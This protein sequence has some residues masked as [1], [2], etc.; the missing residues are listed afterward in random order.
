LAYRKPRKIILIFFVILLLVGGGY[1][2][3]NRL[4]ASN[5]RVNDKFGPITVKKGVK[6]SD[7]DGLADWEEVL[8][9]TDKNNPD[10]D[11]DGVLDG[12]EI[13][14]GRD[15]LIKGPN[16][17]LKRNR[18]KMIQSGLG[19]DSSGVNTQNKPETAIEGMLKEIILNYLDKKI[20]EEK[21]ATL[22]DDDKK[23]LVEDIYSGLGSEFFGDSYSYDDLKIKDDNSINAIRGYANELGSIIKKYGEPAPEPEL[24]VF[25]SATVDGKK[26]E[27]EKL[28]KNIN[29]YE[30]MEKAALGLEVPNVLQEIHLRIVNAFAGL[31]NIIGLWKDFYNDPLKGTM[32]FQ[33]YSDEAE[34]LAEA[35]NDLDS[36]LRNRGINFE[37]GEAGGII[38]QLGIK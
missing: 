35:F 3:Y 9:K 13:K 4:T 37:K 7:N 8:W 28:Q 1:L 15:P 14:E 24:S 33:H 11:G 18:P 36:E 26:E 31:R 30:S 20:I 29:A 12:E 6:D 34:N 19:S 10:T 27:L 2:V 32:A 38:S 16:D 5:K 23:A 21:G 25:M 22:T 17:S